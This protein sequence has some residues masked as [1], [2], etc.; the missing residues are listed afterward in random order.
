[1]RNPTFCS[2]SCIARLFKMRVNDNKECISYDRGARP[3]SDRL[4]GGPA[5]DWSSGDGPTPLR[6]PSRS[7]V[8]GEMAGDGPGNGQPCARRQKLSGVADGVRRAAAV[9]DPVRRGHHLRSEEHTSELQSLMR[10]S[11]AVFCLK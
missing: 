6:H 4:Q 7:R 10:I 11:Y 8:A 2:G 1:M 9:A 3:A 5:K